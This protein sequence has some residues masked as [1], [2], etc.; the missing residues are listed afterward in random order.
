MYLHS[1]NCALIIRDEQSVDLTSVPLGGPTPDISILLNSRACGPL[2][3]R[4]LG[5]VGIWNEVH[6]ACGPLCMKA[7]GHAGLGACGPWGALA[8]GM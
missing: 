1:S 8:L 2:G 5:P 3:K 7:L 6:G 4:I